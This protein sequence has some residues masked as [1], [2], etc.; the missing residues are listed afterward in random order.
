MF[1]VAFRWAIVRT[2]HVRHEWEQSCSPVCFSMRLRTCFVI[3]HSFPG[4][5]YWLRSHLKFD[6]I[7]YEYLDIMKKLTRG[8]IQAQYLHSRA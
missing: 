8:F 1:F 3:V 6:C 4:Y 7:Y 5:L 2:C